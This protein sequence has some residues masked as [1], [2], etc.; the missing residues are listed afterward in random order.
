MITGDKKIDN[1]MEA[2]EAVF[3]LPNQS[4][5][6]P[7]AVA[8]R[9]AIQKLLQTMRYY[10]ECGIMSE[11]VHTVFSKKLKLFDQATTVKELREMEK[12]CLPHFNGHEFVTGAYHIPEEELI[13][14]SMTSL[15]GPL[16]PAG[17]KRYME[18]FRQVFG[19][20][21]HNCTEHDLHDFRVREV[22]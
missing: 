12:G 16:I 19:T 8:K 6:T 18:L 20:D 1:V 22:S 7:F 10:R 9:E 11:L 21:P 14:W 2:A 5:H 15:K 4:E 13:L 3:S 17:L